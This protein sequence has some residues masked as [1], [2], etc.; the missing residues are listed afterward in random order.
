MK[1]LN[2]KRLKTTGYTCLFV[3]VISFFFF[4]YTVNLE[5]FSGFLFLS[6]FLF[7]FLGVIFLV[8]STLSEE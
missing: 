6:A 7:L 5:E 1:I 3:S 8:T 4:L 2:K